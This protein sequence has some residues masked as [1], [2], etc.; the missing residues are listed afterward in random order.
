MAVPH[1][2]ARAWAIGCSRDSYGLSQTT[3]AK[4]CL[5]VMA[6]VPVVEG[7][8]NHPYLGLT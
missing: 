8:P 6:L 7:H 1:V 3:A 4:H 2:L 5:S